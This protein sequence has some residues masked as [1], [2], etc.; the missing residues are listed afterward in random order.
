MNAPLHLSTITAPSPSS[1]RTTHWMRFVALCACM[2]LAACML[3]GCGSQDQNTSANTDEPALVQDGTLTVAASLDF[4]P[5][6][7]LDGTEPTGFA[8]ELMELLANRMGLECSY[9]PSVKFD[10]IVALI[11]SGGKADVGVSSFTINSERIQEIDFTDPYIDSNQGVV[12]TSDSGYTSVED[13]SGKTIGAQSGTTGYEWAVEN[14]TDAHIVAYDEMTAIFA[15]L[16]SGQIDGLVADLPVV[17]SYTKTS[18]PN[19]TIIAQIPTGEQYAII[20][21]KSNPALTAALNEALAEVMA[22]GSYDKLYE[23]YFG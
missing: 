22:D 10:S 5:F 17:Q 19:D 14:I 21:N 7:S 9:L 15:A 8:V 4:P 16:E 1:K 3:G 18:Y 20:V 23:S 2:M 13:L 6:E 11:A 12:V